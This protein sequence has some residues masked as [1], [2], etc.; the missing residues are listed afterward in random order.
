MAHQY[1]RGHPE[2]P[3]VVW[4]WIPSAAVWGRPLRHCLRS[5]MC[6]PRTKGEC[7]KTCTPGI[8][9]ISGH[10]GLKW[11]PGD[12]PRAV[13]GHATAHN[14]AQQLTRKNMSSTCVCSSQHHKP[15]IVQKCLKIMHSNKGRK[16]VPHL[17]LWAEQM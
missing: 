2:A 1:P 9:G 13:A 16:A 4:W 8:L 15:Y 7:D 6:L 17:L 11:G 12:T 10:T 5:Q 3:R 14:A